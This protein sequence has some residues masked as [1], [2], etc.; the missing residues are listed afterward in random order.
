MKDF[1]NSVQHVYIIMYNL[2]VFSGSCWLGP[3]GWTGKY[4]KICT[5]QYYASTT[6]FL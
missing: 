2:H 4:S 6:P 5:V 3:M 1:V